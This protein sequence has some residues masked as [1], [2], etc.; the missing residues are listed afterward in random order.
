MRTYAV[1]EFVDPVAAPLRPVH[2][3]IVAGGSIGASFQAAGWNVD[4]QHIYIGEMEIPETYRE[5]SGL[6]GITLPETLAV[7]AYHFRV[8]KEL[9]SYAYARI[10]E[11]HHPAYLTAMDLRAL[12]GE[13]LFDD[14]KRDA[15]H[16]FIGPPNGG[17]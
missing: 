11:I 6:M 14:S 10:T 16:D 8:D 1:V 17:K 9:Q 3:D 13:I 5:I 2:A 4:K 7:H 12:Y 15:V